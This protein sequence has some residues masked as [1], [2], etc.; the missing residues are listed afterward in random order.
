M[1]SCCCDQL[2]VQDSMVTNLICHIGF[3]AHQVLDD[4][5]CFLPNSTLSLYLFTS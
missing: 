1:L 4:D 2:F 5:I 3:F